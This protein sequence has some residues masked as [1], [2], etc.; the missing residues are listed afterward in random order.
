MISRIYRMKHKKDFEVLFAEGRFVRGSVLSATVWKIDIQKYPRRAYTQET[1]KIG[2]I[3]SKKIEKKAVRRNSI[4]RKMRE[5][6]RMHMKEHTWQTGYL[7]AFVASQRTL[8]ASVSDIYA[9]ITTITNNIKR[10]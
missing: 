4:K 1:L 5:A 7:V 10:I 2:F 8:E 9:D 3:L 6:V